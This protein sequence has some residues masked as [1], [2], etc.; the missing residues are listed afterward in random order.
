VRTADLIIVLD[1]GRI[2]ESGTHAQ[3]MNNGGAYAEL[4]R[5]QARAYL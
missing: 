3:L 5:L 1:R 4:F 2:A